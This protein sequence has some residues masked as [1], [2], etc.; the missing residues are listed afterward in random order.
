MLNNKF[1]NY[2][3]KEDLINYLSQPIKEIEISQAIKLKKSTMI[4]KIV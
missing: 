1:Y 3:A 2:K 4:K